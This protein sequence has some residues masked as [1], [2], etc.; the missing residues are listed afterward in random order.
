MLPCS[1]LTISLGNTGTITPSASISSATV[2]KMNTNAA[3]V[4]GDGDGGDVTGE[5]SVLI[6]DH[7]T[8]RQSCT[9]FRGRGSS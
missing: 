2:M 3:R 8:L 1:K 4:G 7:A 9:L 6:G 5:S